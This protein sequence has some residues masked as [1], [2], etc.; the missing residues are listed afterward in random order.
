MPSAVCGGLVLISAALNWSP[1]A[2]SVT[3][4]PVAVT[5][6]PTT[7]CWQLPTTVTTSRCPRAA[8]RSTQYPF[9][10][11]WNVIR[12][13]TPVTCSDTLPREAKTG[14]TTE[15]QRHRERQKTVLVLQRT[16]SLRSSL[17]LCASVVSP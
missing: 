17:C 14:Q 3:Q 15:A 13:T 5:Y 7:T 1:C 11:L 8:T 6:S 10:S 16:L 12:S 9:S 4:S 2:R